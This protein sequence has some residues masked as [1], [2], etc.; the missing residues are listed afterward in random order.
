MA[1]Q[2]LPEI[3]RKSSAYAVNYDFNDIISGEGYQLFYG[4]CSTTGTTAAPVYTYFLSSQATAS[5]PVGVSSQTASETYTFDSSSI[6]RPLTLKGNLV[7]VIP[8]GLAAGD[9][10]SAC[11]QTVEVEVYHLRGVTETKIGE[12]TGQEI[13]CAHNS[14]DTRMDTLIVALTQTVF[15]PGDVIRIKVIFTR[16]G[17]NIYLQTFAFDPMERVWT[18][19]IGG[20]SGATGITLAAGQ[21]A[22]KF[23]IPFKIIT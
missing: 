9:V 20:G 15:N 19:G 1:E 16:S 6:N 17:N 10:P 23:Y 11:A 7:A 21:T 22:L 4:A 18:H 14:G 8:R 5:T 3:Y 13:S 12:T 2:I